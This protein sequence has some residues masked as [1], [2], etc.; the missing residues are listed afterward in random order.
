M[1][2]RRS[3]DHFV[4]AVDD[5]P[6]A[7]QVYRKLGFSVMPKAR[8]AAIGTANHVIQLHS[9]YVELLGDLDLCIFEPLKQRFA[10]RRAA[11]DG[12]YINCLDSRDLQADRD[13][14]L[15]KGYA[16]G[17]I[18]SARRK[19][20]M[21][22]GSLD[23]T[24][25]DC[26]YVWRDDA[27]LTSTLFYAAH[28]KPHVIWFEPWQ[29]HPNTAMTTL[30]LTYASDNL[31]A[32]EPYFTDLFGTEPAQR[33]VAC[34]IYLTAR[35]ERFEVFTHDTLR[36]R[37]GRQTPARNGLATLGV[38]IRYGVASLH[39]CRAALQ[40]TGVPFAEEAGV[41]T[42]AANDACG[43]VTEFAQLPTSR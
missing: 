4:I 18:I 28:A 14:L 32:D 2:T 42:V 39:V 38:G 20:A 35:G 17:E 26:F 5:L 37:Y 30:S 41:I 19:V 11:G 29:S 9:T 31:Q 8:H 7:E 34:L 21:P 12:F 33:N 36:T 27:R 3:L 23:E 24:A 15:A 40:G 10:S 25:S 43:V 13:A 6:K 22:D 1:N 16:C